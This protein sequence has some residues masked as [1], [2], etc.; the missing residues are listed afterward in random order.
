MDDGMKF[1]S[2]QFNIRYVYEVEQ[3]NSSSET[4]ESLKES[5]MKRGPSAVRFRCQVTCN[6]A[7]S[8]Q[9]EHKSIGCNCY[10]VTSG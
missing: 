9:N 3:L 4:E 8:L 10:R 1:T 6:I 5:G 7:E 2:E